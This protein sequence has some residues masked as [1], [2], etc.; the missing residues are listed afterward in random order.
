MDNLALDP[1]NNEQDRVVL[2]Q[3]Q[4]HYDTLRAAAI[5][6]QQEQQVGNTPNKLGLQLTT[7]AT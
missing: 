7:E 3:V 5:R 4:E 2:N 1:V 6:P